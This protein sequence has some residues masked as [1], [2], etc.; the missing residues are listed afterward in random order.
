MYRDFPGGPVAKTPSFQCR[1]TGS[2]PGHGT[3][4]LHAIWCSKKKKK[5]DSYLIAIKDLQLIL[6]E[7]RCIIKKITKLEFSFFLSFSNLQI[8]NIYN[9]KMSFLQILQTLKRC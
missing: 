9:E 5:I 3:K 1:G 2:V 7:N 8:I 6:K 4:I